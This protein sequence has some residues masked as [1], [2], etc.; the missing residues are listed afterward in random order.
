LDSLLKAL[1]NISVNHSLFNNQIVGSDQVRNMAVQKLTDASLNTALPLSGRLRR[2]LNLCT[3]YV[4]EILSVSIVDG[5]EDLTYWQAKIQG[6]V[7]TPYENGV[8][9]LDLRIPNEFPFH[10][11]K[12]TFQTKVFH[13]NISSKGE[14][15]LDILQDTWSPAMTIP[16]TL[17]SIV[18]LLSSPNAVDFIAP[19]RF[20]LSDDSDIV[21]TVKLL[22]D[23]VNEKVAF[24]SQTSRG[25]RP[26]RFNTFESLQSKTFENGE[27]KQSLPIIEK[28]FAR[29]NYPTQT[30]RPW[31][32]DC[33]YITQKRDFNYEVSLFMKTLQMAAFKL[34]S[35]DEHKKLVDTPLPELLRREGFE[36]QDEEQSERLSDVLLSIV[37]SRKECKLCTKSQPK[38]LFE[39]AT[40]LVSE[41][42][43]FDSED[44]F[45]RRSK[46]LLNEL[47][48]MAKDEKPFEQR[49][50]AKYKVLT[51]KSMQFKTGRQTDELGFVDDVL[52]L[53]CVWVDERLI[54]RDTFWKDPQYKE[55]IYKLS[56]AQQMIKEDELQKEQYKML[57][58]ELLDVILQ[59]KKSKLRIEEEENKRFVDTLLPK[60]LEIEELKYWKE[61]CE[62]LVHGLT[63]ILEV[64]GI[65][66]ILGNEK[67]SMLSLQLTKLIYRTPEEVGQGCIHLYT[68]NTFLYSQINRF[69]READEAEVETYAPFVRLLHWYFDH[70]SSIEIHSINV[71]RGMQLS[72]PIIE[73]YK[74]AAKRGES[75]RWAGFSSTSRCRDVAEFFGNNTLFIMYLRK[76]HQKEKKAVDISRY[77]QF[78]DEE[79]VLLK[80]GVEYT[81]EKV[82]YDGEKCYIYL[83][84]YV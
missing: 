80:A 78:P 56:F 48:F 27:S 63:E 82:E 23:E 75:Y 38:G 24:K 7:G 41:N 73:D 25:Y 17:L 26:E 52:N 46:T 16:S 59:E 39:A 55:L 31:N 5:N 61:K 8:F 42:N 12:V 18:S 69:L 22:S 72:Q 34:R 76:L 32:D 47:P 65:D 60:L 50:D 37:L 74:E 30:N 4:K 49:K 2:E 77:S 44:F 35:K 11:P 62:I 70:S 40:M 79:E 20:E 19:T 13:P 9:E 51:T 45:E 67:D 43:T 29:G 3:N 71:Y 83:I 64:E 81:I 84:V 33:Y 54:P 10:P 68:M 21:T 53:E 28:C 57:A 66:K 14:I 6:P 15:C 36:L 1:N 58:N